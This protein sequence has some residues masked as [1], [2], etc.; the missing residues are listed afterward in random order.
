VI[1]NAA[2][3]LHFQSCVDS[4]NTLAVCPAG[5]FK[6]TVGSP[7]IKAALAFSSDQFSTITSLA[8]PYALDEILDLTLGG[9]ADTA[10]RGRLNFA[11]STTLSQVV[12]EPASILLLGTAL[13]G[14]GA[15]LRRRLLKE[16]A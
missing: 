6:S 11:A 16:N 13:F 9:G 14:F 3:L 4:G 8:P 2:N 12:P 15:I 1:G 7:P 10:H 5:S